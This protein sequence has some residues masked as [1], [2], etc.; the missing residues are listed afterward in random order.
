M[1]WGLGAGA[2]GL[3]LYG[4]I[5]QNRA[6]DDFEGGCGVNPAGVI[7]MLPGSAQ[8]IQGCRDLKAAVDSNFRLE[9]I[10]FVG[11]AALAGAGL[12]LWL[13]EPKPGTP[14]SVAVACLPNVTPDGRMMVGCSIRM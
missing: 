8:S 12:A 6:A 10:G 4:L 3:G 14:G 1:A 7:E 5:Q 9:V 2:A 11:A 13:T